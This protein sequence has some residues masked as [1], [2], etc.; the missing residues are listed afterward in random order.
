MAEGDLTIGDLGPVRE[1]AL[2]GPDRGDDLG[3]D[4]A[5][6]VEGAFDP[7][8]LIDEFGRFD[9]ASTTMDTSMLEGALGATGGSVSSSTS[10]GA[11]DAFS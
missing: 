6:T 11:R 9:A 10:S 8:L 1:F 3:L 2:V 7:P 4:G 5:F